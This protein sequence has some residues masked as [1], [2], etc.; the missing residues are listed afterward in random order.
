MRCGT[1]LLLDSLFNNV[2]A[3]RRSPLFIDFDAYERAALSPAAFESLTGVVIKTH[4]PH[5]PLAAPYA[6]SLAQLAARAMVLTPCRNSI[7]V[8]RSLAKWG[9]VH[10]AAE[11]EE[12]KSRFDSFWAPFA[13]QTIDFPTLLDS[14]G[15]EK[16]IEA[17]AKGTGFKPPQ[18]G[19][20]VMPANTRWGVYCDK[21][22][23]R[24]LGARAP[25]I[26]TTIGY[27][28]PPKQSA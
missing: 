17:V 10:S 23:T 4:F 2:P 21:I 28:L 12:I 11:F 14:A 6:G 15:I 8:R 9:Q 1:H 5:M 16:L 22:L 13:P 20:P 24:M 26:N 27:R 3:L 25:R 19:K 18:P 7:E